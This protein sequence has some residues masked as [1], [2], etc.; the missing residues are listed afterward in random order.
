MLGV[1]F[2]R[3]D[4]VIMCSV[5]F[6]YLFAHCGKGELIIAHFGIALLHGYLVCKIGY[7]FFFGIE[8]PIEALSCTLYH[9]HGCE[10]QISKPVI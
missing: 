10:V 9:F 6:E 1:I 3:S 7:C 8:N 2:L 5:I 4:T